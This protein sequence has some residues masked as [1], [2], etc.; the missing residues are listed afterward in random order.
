MIRAVVLLLAVLALAAF[1]LSK[2]TAKRKLG[3]DA[4]CVYLGA[5]DGPASCVKGG[6]KYLCDSNDCIPVEKFPAERN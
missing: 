2:D 3:D 4:Q 5:S 6:Q 1:G